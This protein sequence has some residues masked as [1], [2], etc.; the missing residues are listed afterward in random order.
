MGLNV[1]REPEKFDKKFLLEAIR[2]LLPEAEFVKDSYM[3]DRRDEAV[4][5]LYLEV[6]KRSFAPFTTDEIKQL[7]LK[8]GKQLKKQIE[9]D[10]HPI[11]LP[12]NEEDVARNLI[13][14]SQQLGL[15]YQH[16]YI[17]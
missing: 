9:S 13:L 2:T 7:R 1:L 15:L 16:P 3:C 6:A 14:L 11:F 10:V 17:R 5:I 8:L 12:R 4:T